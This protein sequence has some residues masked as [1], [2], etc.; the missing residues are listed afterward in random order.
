MPT[1]E[2]PAFTVGDAASAMGGRLISGGATYPIRGVSIDSRSLSPNEL[3]FAIRGERF[4]GH[5]FVTTALQ[6]GACG[7]VVS[8]MKIASETQVRQPV[9][10]IITVDDTTRA[11][12]RLAQYLRR[13][14]GAQV[15]AITGSVGK[16]FIAYGRAGSIQS[17]RH[18]F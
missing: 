16:T 9:A 3:F 13:A 1:T 15:V 17:R 2:L 8:D 11:L 7:V 10:I 18:R 4:N 5:A 12:Q 14:S 6:R